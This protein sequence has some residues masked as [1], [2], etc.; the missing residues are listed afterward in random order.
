MI[1]KPNA[2]H[3]SEAHFNPLDYLIGARLPRR[4]ATLC[5]SAWI[6][7]VPFGL[8]VIKMVEPRIL[9][10]LGTHSGVSYCS[11]CEAIN[12]LR[13]P[14]RSFAVDTWRGDT[15]TQAYGDEIFKELSAHHDDHY[16]GFSQLVRSTFD[17]ALPRFEHG[18][19]DLL[20]IDGYHTYEAVKH[21]FVQ[22]LPKMSD[23]GIVLF[24]DIA[25]RDKPT[26]E[27][28]RLWEELKIEYPHFEFFHSHG[29]GVLAVGALI[30]APLINLVRA[31]KGEAERIRHYFAGLGQMLERVQS[32]EWGLRTTQCPAIPNE[33]R[34][35]SIRIAD[36]FSKRFRKIMK[37]V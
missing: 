30:P 26:F 28:W 10:E 5:P 37:K 36:G 27:V 18:T 31:S 3:E 25:V 2:D 11:F 19:I 32:L 17:G 4:Y 33:K 34:S 35:W 13:L 23:R 29:L 6:G 15:H 8:S 20:H 14:T 16:A 22:W 21:D 24:H 7:H 9:V 12:E 1:A